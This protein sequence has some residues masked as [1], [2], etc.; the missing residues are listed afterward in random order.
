MKQYK[1]NI[2]T[3][4]MVVE[5]QTKPVVRTTREAES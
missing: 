3:T 1:Q 5:V 4:Q 2:Q